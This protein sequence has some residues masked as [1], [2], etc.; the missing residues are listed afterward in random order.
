VIGCAG[1]KRIGDNPYAQ[2]WYEK[3]LT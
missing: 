3:P 1:L 2:C